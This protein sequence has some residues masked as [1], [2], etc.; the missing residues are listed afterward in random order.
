MEREIEAASRIK[1]SNVKLSLLNPLSTR[2]LHR[3]FYNIFSFAA[4]Q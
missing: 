1:I 3:I 2:I 4:E